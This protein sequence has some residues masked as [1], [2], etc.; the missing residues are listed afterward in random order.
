MYYQ[1]RSRNAK[2]WSL[3]GLS[4]TLSSSHDLTINVPYIHLLPECRPQLDISLHPKTIP[5]SWPVAYYLKMCQFHFG[6]FPHN[7]LEMNTPMI[8]N[9]PTSRYPI[10]WA[11]RPG[12]S[13]TCTYPPTRK[14]LSQVPT[15]NEMS[16]HYL[17]LYSCIQIVKYTSISGISP[18]PWKWWFM[19]EICQGFNSI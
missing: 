2:F 7:S 10:R 14:L 8:L 11:W 3:L 15:R 13:F 12:N 16:C 5:N 19:S 9:D 4:M 1:Y 17:R 18:L 6:E